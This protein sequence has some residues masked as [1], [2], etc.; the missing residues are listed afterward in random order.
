MPK[1]RVISEPYRLDRFSPT[2][3]THRRIRGDESVERKV[4]IID[5]EDLFVALHKTIELRDHRKHSITSIEEIVPSEALYFT[6]EQLNAVLRLTDDGAAAADEAGRLAPEDYH[7]EIVYERADFVDIV[8]SVAKLLGAT[9]L[10]GLSVSMVGDFD[11]NYTVIDIR[12]VATGLYVSTTSDI[13][14]LTHDRSAV[15]WDGILSV[16]RALIA[17]AEPLV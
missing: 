7:G 11:D 3:P 17:A 4:T 6:D 16:A 8:E 1:F 10:P 14:D 5:A 15:G 12:D 9:L 13:K 2:I